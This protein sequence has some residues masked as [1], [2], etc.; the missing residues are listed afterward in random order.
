MEWNV[1]VCVCV[2]LLMHVNRISV[3]CKHRV[4]EDWMNNSVSSLHDLHC[5]TCAACL[6]CLWVC[7][8]VCVF[9]G[10]EE[11]KKDTHLIMHMITFVFVWI[12]IF[13]TRSLRGGGGIYLRISD[14]S[15]EKKKIMVSFNEKILRLWFKT[16]NISEEHINSKSPA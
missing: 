7:A 9:E 16:N 8:C 10:K 15:S 1:C 13:K 4:T 3:L 2:L 11:N 12:Y 14:K 5:S 6:Q